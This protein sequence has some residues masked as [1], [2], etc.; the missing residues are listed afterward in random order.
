MVPFDSTSVILSGC[1][2]VADIYTI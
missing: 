1:D 2:S